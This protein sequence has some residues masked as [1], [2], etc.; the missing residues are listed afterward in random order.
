MLEIFK[1]N[2]TEENQAA[3]IISL[4]QQHMPACAIN[5]DLKDCDNILRI[6]GENFCVN[7]IIQLLQ[8]LGYSCCLLH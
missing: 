7:Q 1:T 2:V 4:L 6:K 8:Q 5:F 3:A